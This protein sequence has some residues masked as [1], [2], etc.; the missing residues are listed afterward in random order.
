MPNYCEHDMVV[1]AKDGSE[2]CDALERFVAQAQDGENVLSASKFIPYPERFAQLDAEAREYEKAHPNGSW[3]DRP[4][5]G[6]N[7]GGYQWCCKHWGTK[8]GFGE[9]EIKEH[10]TGYIAVYSFKSAWA[11]PIPVFVEMA[12][13]Y[14]EL[15]FAIYYYERGMQFQG[16]WEAWD[17]HRQREARFYYDGPRGG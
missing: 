10:D 12:R 14:P 5:D 8:W 7:S 13:Q 3:A 9:A 4:T 2:E 15:K 16:S 11:P 1:M 17:G 6:F